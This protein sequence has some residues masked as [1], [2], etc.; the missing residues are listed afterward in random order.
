MAKRRRKASTRRRPA[1]RKRTR[2]VYRRAKAAPR[3][4]ARARSRRRS[5]PSM[6]GGPAVRLGAAAVAGGVVATYLESVDAVAD[7]GGKI[8][9]G[10]AT[11]TGIALWIL[12][13]FAL[14]GGNRSL[15]YAAAVGAI[16]RA[17]VD[18][19]DNRD[20][21]SVVSAPMI[22]SVGVVRQIKAPSSLAPSPAVQAFVRPSMPAG[23]SS[24]ADTAA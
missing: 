6:F 17:A 4:R 9:G 3:A 13:R 1:A 19:M 7:L 23:R 5:N 16:G 11:V 21:T 20:T 15:A 8:P 2:V 22:A 14:R 24:R 12:G 10:T 18:W